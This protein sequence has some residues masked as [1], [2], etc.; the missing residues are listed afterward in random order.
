LNERSFADEEV[1]QTDIIED[2]LFGFHDIDVIQAACKIVLGLLAPDD[3]EK[4]SNADPK[5]VDPLVHGL[6]AIDDLKDR[7]S[8]NFSIP[9]QLVDWVSRFA[10]YRQP[11]RRQALPRLPGRQHFR[12]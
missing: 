2:Q 4:R 12:V 3:F 5:H 9:S 6:G 1:L 7:S 8:V 11:P 10:L